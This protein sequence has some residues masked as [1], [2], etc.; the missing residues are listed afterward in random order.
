MS[1]TSATSGSATPTPDPVITDPSTLAAALRADRDRPDTYQPPLTLLDTRWR[2]NRPSAANDYLA[3]HI[4]G[5]IFVELATNGPDDAAAPA[6]G[7][8]GT[9]CGP[10]AAG[11]G[12]HPLPDPEALQETLRRCGLRETSRVVIYDDGDGLPAARAWWTLRWAGLRDVR[13]LDGGYAAWLAADGPVDT[14][15]PRPARGDLTVTP[16]QLPVL[17]AD[18]AAE[19]AAAGV[20]LDVR[21]GQ[22]YRGETEPIDPVAGHIPGAV[23]LPMPETTGPD[24]SLL[25]ADRLRDRFA[26]AG[27][28]P[29][30][31]V[32]VYCG[33][34]ITAAHTALAMT[35]A[36]LHPAVYVGSWSD[37]ISD[38]THPVATGPA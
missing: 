30:T 18:D 19:L 13:V 6:G 11:G 20:L 14:A 28:T 4:P 16:G 24:G 7:Q 15:V 36:G 5:A 32:G 29:A 25:P 26:A 35:V 27:V 34:G 38:P 31:P 2:L 37:W 3:G 21:A 1:P 12:R 33:S 8:T 10:H 22:R 17:D 23:N 9:L